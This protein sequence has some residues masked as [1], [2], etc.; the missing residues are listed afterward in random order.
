MTR[1]TTEAL[2]TASAVD[3]APRRR[4]VDLARSGPWF[5]AFFLLALIA[6]WPSYLSRLGAQTAYTHLH[7]VTAAVWM[8]LLIAQPVLIRIR[9]FD[10]HR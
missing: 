2:D 10:L 9:R 8:T 6:F 4:P 1:V 5:A 7:A 3:G